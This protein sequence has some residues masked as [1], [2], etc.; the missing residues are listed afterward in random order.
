MTPVAKGKQQKIVAATVPAAPS[1]PASA[2]R[3][4]PCSFMGRTFDDRGRYS[5]DRGNQV[6]QATRPTR[7]PHL[8][9]ATPGVD[10][11]ADPLDRCGPPLGLEFRPDRRFGF[12]EA[13]ADRSRSIGKLLPD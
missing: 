13:I 4:R 6:T 12:T 9:R 3:D 5:L 11:V 10:V 7:I 1:A 8:A 2:H